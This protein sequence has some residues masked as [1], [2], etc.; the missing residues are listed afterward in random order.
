MSFKPSPGVWPPVDV[1]IAKPELASL[2]TAIAILAVGLAGYGGYRLLADIGTQA[3]LAGWLLVG[4]GWILLFPQLFLGL[5]LT[6]QAVEVDILSGTRTIPLDEIEDVRIVD[7]RLL[8][9]LGGVGTT[10]Y[11]TGTFY[12]RGEGKL[13]AYASRA[14]GPFVLLERTADGSVV[15]SPA[16]LEGFIGELTDRGVPAP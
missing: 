4:V 10:A 8:V 7:G 12:L 9:R 15:L 1:E 5:R 6:D 16:D 2:D 11:H 13:K 3:G 14:K